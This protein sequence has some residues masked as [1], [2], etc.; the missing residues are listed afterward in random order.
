V[1]QYQ[2]FAV[3][4]FFELEA[5]FQELE[6]RLPQFPQGRRYQPLS[7]G[8]PTNTLV[9]ECEFDSL[10][11][12]QEALKKMDDDPMHTALFEKQAP[13]IVGMR[14]EIYKVLDL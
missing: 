2:P 6:R 14:T 5:Q 1:Q 8:E 9:W 11:E 4:A 13:C 7:G 12:V 10:A 3:R